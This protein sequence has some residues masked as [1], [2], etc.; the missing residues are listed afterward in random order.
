MSNGKRQELRD[1]ARAATKEPDAYKERGEQLGIEQPERRADAPE[2]SDL[3]SDQIANAFSK[4][5]DT[6]PMW[7][8]WDK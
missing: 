5:D 8:A 3:R 6:Y 1:Q 4:Q 2:R 7:G